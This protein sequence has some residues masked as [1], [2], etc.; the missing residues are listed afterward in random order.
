MSDLCVC[1]HSV[2]MHIDGQ[3]QCF[4]IECDCREFEEMQ[5]EDAVPA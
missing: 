4:D 3:E 2:A 5:D 1:G